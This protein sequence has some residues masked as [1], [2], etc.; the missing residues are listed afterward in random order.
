[1]ILHIMLITSF[2]GLCFTFMKQRLSEVFGAVS[3]GIDGAG[4]DVPLRDNLGD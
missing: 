2:S 4:Y 1:M 3:V